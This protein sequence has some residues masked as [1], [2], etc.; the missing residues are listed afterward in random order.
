[1]SRKRA[2]VRY[3]CPDPRY[4]FNSDIDF[5]PNDIIVP[6]PGVFL[7]N[8]GYLFEKSIQI[9]HFYDSLIVFM[10]HNPCIAVPNANIAYRNGCKYADFL[11]HQGVQ[12]ISLFLGEE[13]VNLHDPRGD[14]FDPK[15][16]GLFIDATC[17]Q[18]KR[19][20]KKTD[21]QINEVAIA[22]FFDLWEVQQK[23]TLFLSSNFLTVT[24]LCAIKKLIG[25]FPQRNYDK[26][27][28]TVTKNLFEAAFSVA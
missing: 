22:P 8:V 7:G 26:K 2:V 3:V 13:A 9:P 28:D 17:A 20:R 5:E 15:V 23:A 6:V 19:Y 25:A 4:D 21:F 24:G 12:A 18:R 14:I 1:M 11:N 10:P 27:I 16:Q